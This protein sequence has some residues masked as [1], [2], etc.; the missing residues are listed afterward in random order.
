MMLCA[1]MPG[2]V[3]AAD[4]VKCLMMGMGPHGENTLDAVLQDIAENYPSVTITATEDVEQL[5]IENLRDYDVLLLHQIKVEGGDPPD[6]V[7]EGLVEFL[8]GG[9]GLVTTHF[10]VANMQAWRDSIDI[11]GAMWVSGKSTHGPYHEFR[12][13]MKDE[14]HPIVAVVLHFVTNDELYYNLLMR[15]DVHVIMTADEERYGHRVPEPMLTTH[16]VHNARC[17]YVALGH[18]IQS[19]AVPEYRQILVQSIEWAACRR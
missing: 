6:F 4:P 8:K 11:L 1:V 18:D 2:G 9:G 16:Y 13:D 19:A 14:T 5:R 10:A 3:A 17:V 15:P 7:K 12:V